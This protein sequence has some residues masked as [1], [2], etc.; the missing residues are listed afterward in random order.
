MGK[1][2][3]ET[4]HYYR[5]ISDVNTAKPRFDFFH[6]DLMLEVNKWFIIWLFALVLWAII[7]Y[8]RRIMPYM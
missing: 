4:L 7:R 8:Y 6:E 3:T 1:S 5:A 2:Q